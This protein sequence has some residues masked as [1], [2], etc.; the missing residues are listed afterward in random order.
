M[1]EKKKNKR[2]DKPRKNKKGKRTNKIRGQI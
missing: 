1:I 2:K